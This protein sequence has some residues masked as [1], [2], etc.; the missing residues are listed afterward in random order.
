MQNEFGHVQ[1][2]PGGNA[3]GVLRQTISSGKIQRRM[4]VAVPMIQWISMGFIGLR[5]IL[6]LAHLVSGTALVIDHVKLVC[7]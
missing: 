2:L 5:C 6:V 1:P 3:F 4:K 7:F